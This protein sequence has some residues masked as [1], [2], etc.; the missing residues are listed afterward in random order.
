M[1]EQLK[2]AVDTD[3]TTRASEIDSLDT[4]GDVT[5]SLNASLD[6]YIKV[7]NISFCYSHNE[8]LGEK[9]PNS[10][11]AKQTACRRANPNG[12]DRRRFAKNL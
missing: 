3:S 1:A 4:I 11:G 6:A 10:I 8:E 12:Q 7:Q 9:T 2:K 5:K